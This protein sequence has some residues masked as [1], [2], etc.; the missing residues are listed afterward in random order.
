MPWLRGDSD[1]DSMLKGDVYTLAVFFKMARYFS[2]GRALA[3]SRRMLQTRPSRTPWR[4]QR[5]RKLTI[6]PRR[7]LRSKADTYLHSFVIPPHRCRD[8]ML[9]QGT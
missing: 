4:R 6:A 2:P 7:N 5:G 3:A 1:S 9:W 8:Q